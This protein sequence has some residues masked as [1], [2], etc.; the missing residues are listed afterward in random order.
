[1]PTS[2][3]I[4]ILIVEDTEND[5]E[6]IV[7]ELTHAGLDLQWQRVDREADYVAALQ[8]DLDVVLSDFHVPGFGALRA[9]ELLRARDLD[10]PFIVVSGSIGEETAV[11]ILR[12]GAADYLL[13]D[14]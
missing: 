14:R 13:K 1:M 2:K 8:P 6:L 5:C 3:P 9:L 10:V 4:R 12:C 11:Q 7:N